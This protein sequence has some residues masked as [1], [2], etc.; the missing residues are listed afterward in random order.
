MAMRTSLPIADA[1]CDFDQAVLE[2]TGTTLQSLAIETIQVNIGLRCNLACKHCHV[3]SSPKRTEEMSW[4]TMEAVLRAATESGARTIDVTGG[5]PEMHPR[6]REFIRRARSLGQHVIV[7][8]N[9][10]IMLVDGYEDL[11]GFFREH[12]IHLIASLPCYLETNV[13]RQRGRHVYQDSI[14]VIRR[15]NAIGYGCEPSRQLDL[16]YNPLGPQLPPNQASLEA[17]YKQA[18]REQFGIEFHRLY[19]LANLPIGR[20]MDDLKRQGLADEYLQLLMDNFNAHTIDGLMCRSQIHVG[21][22]GSIYDCD[23][24][25]ALQLPVANRP[26]IRNPDWAALRRRRIVTG[27][28]CFGCTAGHGS[29]CGGAIV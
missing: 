3:E 28:H 1:P 18:L 17:A 19:A 25:Y 22:D 8:T 27:A 2:S 4:E 15:L 13:D 16:I 10:T 23:F 24:N 6:F 7:R 26:N 11:P 9:L 14:E 12:G 21:W 5:A 20:F 29:S